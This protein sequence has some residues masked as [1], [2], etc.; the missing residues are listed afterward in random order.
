MLRCTDCGKDVRKVLSAWSDWQKLSD[1]LEFQY[2]QGE[3]TEQTYE[4]LFNALLRF[5][6]YAIDTDERN[7]KE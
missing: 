7:E 2:T 6:G 1:F 5:K 3:I 4:V